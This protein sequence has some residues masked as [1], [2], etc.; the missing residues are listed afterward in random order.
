[1]K[2]L[3]VG[4][5]MID[6]LMKLDR[7]PKS[8][9]DVLCSEAG[10]VVGGCAYNVASTLR[11][12]GCALDSLSSDKRPLSGSFHQVKCISV[13]LTVILDQDI[14]SASLY[15]FCN[16]IRRGTISHRNT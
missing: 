10:I 6:M 12:M 2:T 3:V 4:A 15:L 13:I 11:N 1:M 8:G 7:L 9:E 14:I 5:A 16:D